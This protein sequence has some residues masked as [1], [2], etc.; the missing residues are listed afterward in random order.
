MKYNPWRTATFFLSK[1]KLMRINFE[2][3]RTKFI[4]HLKHENVNEKLYEIKLVEKTRL[5]FFSFWRLWGWAFFGVIVLG[6]FI[7]ERHMFVVGLLLFLVLA[8]GVKELFGRVRSF[9]FGKKY[10]PFERELRSLIIDNGYYE[11]DRNGNLLD[12]LFISYSEDEE[13]L[14]VFVGKSGGKYQ[15]IAERLKDKLESAINIPLYHKESELTYCTYVFRKNPVE[16]KVISE[17]PLS[18]ESMKLSIYDNA[19]IDLHKLYSGIISGAS[20]SGKS[21]LTY[22]LIADFASKYTYRK[23]GDSYHKVNAK[24][25]V[26]DPKESDLLKHMQLSDMPENQYG[27]TVAEAFR[28]VK[29]VTAEM[30]KR[31]EIYK[32]STTF[33]STMLS[34]HHEPILLVVD[35]YPSLVASMQKTERV[36]FDKLIG[37]YARLSRQLSLGL[38]VIAQQANSEALPTAI[39]EQLVGFRI[40]MGTPSQQSAQMMFSVSQKDLPAVSQMGEGIISIDGQ[41]P[42]SFL[43][44][45]FS[46]DVNEVIQPVLKEA[47]KNYREITRI[48]AETSDT[49]Q[50]QTE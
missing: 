19:E 41:E 25:Y 5:S 16:R 6:Y 14:V 18:D 32:E 47:S 27:S 9:I 28:I 21:Y 15:E 8:W 36:E 24:L 23:I 50:I 45:R 3:L 2:E 43:S 34:L 4:K 26:I 12:W 33:D 31:Q 40:F 48:E 13:N 37:N 42:V 38:W 22:A 11:Q 30:K 35:E 46:R 29:E 44:A 20:G 39:R 17:M 10:R 49:E 1:G 7:W